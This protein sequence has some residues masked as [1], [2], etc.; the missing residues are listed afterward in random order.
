[1]KVTIIREDQTV[2]KDNFA[3]GPLNI[4]FVPE[5]VHALQ[6]NGVKGWIEFVDDEDFNKPANEII[7][8]LPQWAL[9]AVAIWEVVHTTYLAKLAAAEASR[10]KQAQPISQGAQ[11]L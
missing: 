10:N 8:V 4:S 1:M 6:W 3:H 5:D 7:D 2:Y 11:T 9:D